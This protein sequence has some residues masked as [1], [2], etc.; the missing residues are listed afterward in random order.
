[1]GRNTKTGMIVGMAGLV[2]GVAPTALAQV[3][4]GSI[5][6]VY[7]EVPDPRRMSFDPVTGDLFVGQGAAPNL[8]VPINVVRRSDRSVS[9][10][11]P[12]IQDADA[13]QFDADGSLTGTPGSVLVGSGVGLFAV[14]PDETLTPIITPRQGFMNPTEFVFD[15]LGRLTFTDFQGAAIRLYDPMGVTTLFD[16]QSPE[17]EGLAFGPGGFGQGGMVYSTDRTG[18]IRGHD[19]DLGTT[20]EMRNDNQQER[21]YRWMTTVDERPGFNDGL[22]VWDGTSDQIL[23]FEDFNFASDPVVVGTGFEQVKDLEFG[24]DGSLY[25]TSGL[26]LVYRVTLDPIP[27]PGALA[28]M[29]V[30]LAMGGKRRRRAL[31]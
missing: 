27:A 5:V 31:G 10:F 1:M 3:V 16:N 18:I 24:P 29:G 2:L 12:G 6:E 11:G 9:N 4:P 17:V 21:E 7:A 30:L 22:L 23:L 25:V 14:G 26:G 20:M 28:G 13:V 19:I 8:L 15:G